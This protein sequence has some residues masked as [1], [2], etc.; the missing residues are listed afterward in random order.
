MAN[1]RGA[2]LQHESP[3]AANARVHRCIENVCKR[4]TTARSMGEGD[5]CAA[6]KRWQPLHNQRERAASAWAMGEGGPAT[7]QVGG[8]LALLAAG[9]SCAAAS[10]CS[11]T[12]SEWAMPAEETH[13]WGRILPWG[14]VPLRLSSARASPPIQ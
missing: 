5:H 14:L 6:S 1:A 10:S 9:M 2:S 3:C 4:S 13:A 8:R 7:A 12:G 11:A